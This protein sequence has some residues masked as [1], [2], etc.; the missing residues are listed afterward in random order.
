[1]TEVRVGGVTWGGKPLTVLGKQLEAGDRAP[2]FLLEA[3]DFNEVSLADTAGKVR[4]V[5]VVHSLDTSVCDFQTRRFNQEI[6]N[7][8]DDVVVLAVS[9]E[10]PLNQ[11]RW[12]GAAGVERVV[13]LSDHRDMNFGDAYG[14]HVEERRL[15]QRAIFVIDKN[16]VITYVEYVPEISQH[17]DYDEALAAVAAATK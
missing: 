13:V 1:M 14:T 2:D 17:P 3:R 9:A 4:L 8:G 15:E 6:V 5:S 12:C 11:Q 16:D 10:H 7:L